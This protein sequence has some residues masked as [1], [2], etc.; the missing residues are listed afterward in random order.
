M[1]GRSAKAFEALRAIGVD[2]LAFRGRSLVLR[3]ARRILAI[4]VLKSTCSPLHTGSPLHTSRQRS[5]GMLGGFAGPLREA[6]R[7]R[8]VHATPA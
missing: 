7:G 3:K 8:S 4:I 6:S 2:A 5:V 1:E